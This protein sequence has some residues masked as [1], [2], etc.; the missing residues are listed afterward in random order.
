MSKLGFGMYADVHLYQIP[1]DYVQWVLREFAE[2]EKGY[3][4]CKAEL[5][6]REAEYDNEYD[7]RY[8][9]GTLGELLNHNKNIKKARKVP[10]EPYK[11]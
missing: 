2:G 11:Y 5:D 8:G 3:V 1:D 10:V 6:R 4:M 7:H 9:P